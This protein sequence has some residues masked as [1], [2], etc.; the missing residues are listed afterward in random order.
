MC[1]ITVTN[2]SYLCNVEIKPKRVI[3]FDV[4]VFVE[5]GGWGFPCGTAGG[6]LSCQCRRR[7]RHE[8]DP[9]VRKIPWR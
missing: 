5:V 7:K 1:S 3:F 6:E 2:V 9:W 4:C 8:F